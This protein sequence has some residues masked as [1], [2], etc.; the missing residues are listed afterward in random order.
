MYSD[1]WIFY[2]QN[3]QHV[4]KMKEQIKSSNPIDERTNAPTEKVIWSN[5]SMS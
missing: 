3:F 2:P 5:E 1:S 4:T